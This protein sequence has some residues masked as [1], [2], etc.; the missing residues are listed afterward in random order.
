MSK[1]IKTA[2]MASADEIKAELAK[3]HIEV[4]CTWVGDPEIGPCKCGGDLEVTEIGE[5]ELQRVLHRPGCK[6]AGS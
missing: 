5:A 2:R 3:A 1:W 6:E 4:R